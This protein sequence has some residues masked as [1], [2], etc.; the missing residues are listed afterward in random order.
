[1]STEA[2]FLEYRPSSIAA[3]AILCAANEIPNLSLVN[4]EHAESWCDGLSKE[5]IISC[6][7]LMQ[8]LVLNDSRRKQPKVIPQLR[9][10]IR[11]RMR[12]SCDSSSSSSSSS[13]PTYKR[14]KLNNYLWVGDDK[15][16]SE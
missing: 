8:R 9:V 6:Y 11:A 4:P 14:R 3:A 7:R 2:S 16:G 13:S 12:S 5:K 15:G 1:M 10:T